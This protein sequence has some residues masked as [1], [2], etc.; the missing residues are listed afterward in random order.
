MTN[1]RQLSFS[2]GE[3]APSLQGRVD[4]VKYA[5]GLKTCRNF[6]VQRHGGV[7]N[8]PGTIFD[9]E[10]N[11]SSK[12]V[13][14]IPFVFNPSQTYVLE[15]GNLYMRVHQN[16]ALLTETA[17]NIVSITNTNPCVMGVTTHGCTTGDEIA[18]ASIG[19]MTEL[20]G[21]NFK[22]TVLTAD[23]FELQYMDGT[24]VDSTLFDAYTS[25]GTSAKI[26]EIVTVYFEAHLSELQ[27]VQSA[28]IITLVHPLYA[29][30]DLSRTGHTAW[31][32]DVIVFGASLGAPEN[33][34]SDA[35]GAGNFFQITAVNSE[36]GEESLPSVLVEATTRTSTLSW[37]AVAG[38]DYYEVYYGVNSVFGWIG[39][40]ITESFIDDT[41]AE[42]LGNNPPEDRQP[43][44][45][46]GNYP[47]AVSFYQQRLLLANSDNFPERVW[48]SKTGLRKNFMVSTPLQDDDAITF[49][50]VG[51]QVN[52]V[53]H[54]LDI[55]SLVALT[56][57]SVY[58]PKGDAAGTL[59]PTEVN[60]VRQ[61]GAGAA[62]Q[63]PIE[64]GDSALYVQARGSVIRDV[65]F[66]F[67]R[68][69][70]SGNEV[71]IFA[72]HLFDKFTIV[73]WA[74]QE[75][76]N[77]IIWVVRNDG[78]LL[79]LTYIRE[80]QVIGWHRHD[81][82]G[83]VENVCVVPEGTEDALYLTIKRTVDGKTVRYVERMATRQIV[84]I[85]DAIFMDS[86]LSYDGE[87]LG[88]IT[89]T[90]AGGSEWIH[91]EDLTLTASASFFAS[92]DIGNAIFLT[93]SDGTLIRCPIKAY[94]S[95][96]VVTVNPHK[97]VPASMQSVAI[98]SWGKAV[99]AISG[100]WHLEGKEISVF[101][102]GFVVANPNNGAYNV[103]TV[104]DGAVT[105]DKPYLV[106][107]AGLPITADI[108]TLNID[109]P[110]VS[111][112]S[113]KKKNISKLTSLVEETRG[114]WVGPDFDTLTEFKLRS[115]EGYDDPVDLATD[116][117]DLNIKAEWK[118]SGRIAIRQIDPVPATIL[119]VVP[120]GY[121][122]AS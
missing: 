33:P 72:N 86:T 5:T 90:L 6:M 25:G 56:T 51:K 8:R 15:F 70:Y 111:S 54:L 77:S 3:I 64:V 122:S 65:L 36:T 102:D 106:I 119:T 55:G 26:Y 30:R 21:R 114:L 67:E 97:T 120:T 121:I 91:E 46:V 53:Q 116:T 109:L 89:M 40:S 11:D 35:S 43:F 69:G 59:T 104:E 66:T 1:V 115:D 95:P 12:A 105:L 96:T 23:T 41:F 108:E 71:T 99:D 112:M 4:Q 45:G 29:P 84:D 22:I 34:V 16:G 48:T 37:D 113:D 38:A 92:S 10:V 61:T 85:E 44:I 100:L 7:T 27:Y 93:G 13:R 32:F 88:A 14:L 81:T 74:Y 49:T 78:V 57:S 73:D 107:H 52:E 60:P 98:T 101:G 2:S 20:N 83:L 87:H 82:D 17:K 19:G 58:N 28:D 24:D 94:T 62:I 75:I 63:T 42:D 79:G 68:E 103:L 31:S 39:T 9:A 80:H 118:S 47:S 18:A 50:I 110:G 76:P 117:I